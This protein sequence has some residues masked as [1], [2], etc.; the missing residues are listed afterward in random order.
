V[1]D[2][3]RERST[4][5][6]EDRV[7]LLPEGVVLRVASGPEQ[8]RELALRRGNRYS[9]G[10]A[11]DGDLVL[12]DPTVSR[13]HCEVVVH[14]DGI[15][16]VD[17]DS[18]NGSYFRGAQ[19]DRVK[20]GVG[21]KLR[22]GGTELELRVSD[23]A[24]GSGGAQRFGDMVGEGPATGRLFEQLRKV[25]AT[26]VSVLIQ[27]ETGTGKEL[28]ARGIHE[29]SARRSKPFV[30][31]DLAGVARTLIESELFGHVRGAFTGANRDHAG[32]FE[33]AD[34]GTIFLDEVGELEIEMQPRLLR[35]LESGKVKRVGSND[36][37]QFNVRVL[38]ATNRDLPTEVKA[39]RFRDDLF[40]RLAVMR[41]RLPPLRERRADIPGLVQHFIA[42]VAP[43]AELSVDD[44]T[45]VALSSHDWP[46]NLRQLRNV[47][48]R[49]V[50]LSIGRTELDGSMLGL[51]EV[52]P[53]AGSGAQSVQADV[54]VPFKDAKERLVETWERD[55]LETLLDECDGNVSQAARRAGLNR[56]HFHRLLRKHG[57]RS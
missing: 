21:A 51:D 47:I 30:V 13:S 42:A 49:A 25:A 27:G 55:Y 48:E 9:V 33:R 18:H 56:V 44:D 34:G 3:Q 35:A 4:V 2:E 26:D 57:L 31:C 15:E 53:R 38:A 54:S 20:V 22:I 5:T 11:D 46:G 1:S 16:V 37:R 43:T 12:S 36:Y 28:T 29:A 8:G 7:L 40:H 41:V 10:S 14:H 19:F 52:Q 24:P 45:I 23:A 32:V 6:A 39:G 50:A 17:L